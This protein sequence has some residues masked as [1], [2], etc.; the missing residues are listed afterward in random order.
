MMQM[1]Y[2]GSFYVCKTEEIPKR[3]KEYS[4]SVSNHFT[5]SCECHQSPPIFFPLYRSKSNL[6]LPQPR[7]QSCRKT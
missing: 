1:V 4:I 7:K 6:K 3:E 5:N 2:G